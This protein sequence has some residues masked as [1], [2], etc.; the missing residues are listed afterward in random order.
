MPTTPPSKSTS[1]SG[2]TI[3]LLNCYGKMGMLWMLF[4]VPE[5]Q[6][7]TYLS[8]SGVLISNLVNKFSTFI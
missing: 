5:Y 6:N 4:W 7:N 8:H 1:E 2:A 3:L